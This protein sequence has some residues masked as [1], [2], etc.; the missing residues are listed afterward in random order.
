LTSDANQTLG[1]IAILEDV[2]QLNDVEVVAE[3]SQMVAKN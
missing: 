2:A 3:Q 1:T